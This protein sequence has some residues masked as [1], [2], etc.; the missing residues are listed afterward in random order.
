MRSLADTAQTA[1]L[2]PGDR[3]LDRD[4]AEAPT[5][6]LEKLQKICVSRFFLASGS[7]TDMADILGGLTDTGLRKKM[8]ASLA[9]LLDALPSG[10]LSHLK[11][12]VESWPAPAV[13]TSL[14]SRVARAMLPE[15]E[16]LRGDRLRFAG[17][18]APRCHISPQSRP[19]HAPGGRRASP[20]GRRPPSRSQ[21]V[22][23]GSFIPGAWVRIGD[24]SVPSDPLDLLG[25]EVDAIVAGEAAKLDELDHLLTALTRGLDD[26]SQP[27]GVLRTYL[28]PEAA[29]ELAAVLGVQ[30]TDSDDS[31]A[32]SPSPAKRQP[33][34][35]Q[36]RC[37]LLKAPERQRRS[38]KPGRPSPRIATPSPAGGP[39]ESTS[40]E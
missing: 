31:T 34:L 27:V 40:A 19:G 22:E 10:D 20:A 28:T 6:L 7:A 38:R 37:A 5:D 3:L 24:F 8:T 36:L 23:P 25:H 4:G 11:E 30:E 21:A 2:R 26:N 12:V 35:E 32:P 14:L 17:D 18:R 33:N 13:D 1:R 15:A 16:G 39:P 29:G 9:E